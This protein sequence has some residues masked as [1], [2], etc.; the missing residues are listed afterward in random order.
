[1]IRK[2]TPDKVVAIRARYVAGVL[3]V[4]RLAKEYGVRH[5][6]VWNVVQR[7]SWRHVS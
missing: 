7:K 3:G 5:A 1:M 6:T 2:L 4:R